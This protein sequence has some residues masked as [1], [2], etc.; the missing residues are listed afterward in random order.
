MMLQYF[1]CDI[2]EMRKAKGC[3]TELSL[4]GGL[5]L[6]RKK[7][8]LYNMFLKTLPLLFYTLLFQNF[9]PEKD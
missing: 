9:K 1:L 6:N 7:E 3:L 4:V 2:S 8:M 5:W